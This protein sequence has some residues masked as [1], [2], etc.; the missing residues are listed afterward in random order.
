MA[1]Q[2]LTVP[3][4]FDMPVSFNLA[5]GQSPNQYS[6]GSFAPLGLT[7]ATYTTFPVPAS[8]QFSILNFKLLTSLTTDLYV[9]YILDGTVQSSVVDANYFVATLLN[10]SRLAAPIVVGPTHT[11]SIIAYPVSTVTTAATETITAVAMLA[12]VKA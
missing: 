12:P 10:P 11:I 2:T 7:G 8:L 6:L 1:N 3:I 9:S 5:A 4:V